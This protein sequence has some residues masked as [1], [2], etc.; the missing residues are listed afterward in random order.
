MVRAPSRIWTETEDDKFR[1]LAVAGNTAQ[2]IATE[3]GRSLHAV[4][5][6]AKK[7][8]I[9]LKQITVRARSRYRP[10]P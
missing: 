5:A 4:G 6:R 9:S 7:L 1:A 3:L 8:G 2:Q 10:A